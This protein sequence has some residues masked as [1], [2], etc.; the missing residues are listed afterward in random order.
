MQNGLNIRFVTLEDFNKLKGIDPR[1]T[2][3]FEH[4]VEEPNLV[5]GNYEPANTIHKSSENPDDLKPTKTTH[6]SGCN[7]GILIANGVQLHSHMMFHLNSLEKAREEFGDKIDE[8]FKYLDEF[9]R[10][11]EHNGE[12]LSLEFVHSGGLS[13]ILTDKLDA[14]KSTE[15]S[16]QLKELLE[17]MIIER[18]TKTQEIASANNV[19]IDFSRSVF[20]GQKLIGQSNSP[21]GKTLS[22]WTNMHYDPQT[23]TLSINA[24]RGSMGQESPHAIED[25]LVPAT[26]QYIAEHYSQI[27]LGG[28]HRSPQAQEAINHKTIQL[29]FSKLT[30]EER[31]RNKEKWNADRVQALWDA[32]YSSPGFPYHMNGVDEGGQLSTGVASR[33][34]YITVHYGHEVAGFIQDEEG[35]TKTL[36]AGQLAEKRIV[37]PGPKN[38]YFFTSPRDMREVESTQSS[39]K[40]L[41]LDE[42]LAELVNDLTNPNKRVAIYSGAGI[43]IA[44]G[45]DDINRYNMRIAGDIGRPSTLKDFQSTAA[46][47]KADPKSILKS[48]REFYESLYFANPSPAHEAIA[49]LAI[50]LPN[51]LLV[52]TENLDLLHQKTGINVIAMKPANQMKPYLNEDQLRQLD[53]I[54]CTGLS[55]DDRGFIAY[56]REINPNIRIIGNALLDQKPYFIDE[57]NSNDV[58]LAANAHEVFPRLLDLVRQR[59]MGT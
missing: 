21:T 11:K 18:L 5:A 13:E 4:Q 14:K 50:E 15:E 2:N 17:E 44:A 55:H 28:N 57:S 31:G 8:F 3:T 47:V 53:C 40:S 59:K 22:S 49:E 43:S 46:R 42:I 29:G 36:E 23:N 16:L 20:W 58:Y 38:D 19:Q 9:I 56:L 39:V 45:V 30:Q 26:D 34:T 51:P 32:K 37:G 25:F 7:T 33:S 35:N 6:A 27:E 54:V 24:R 41:S 52:F 48:V 1:T 12:T 10:S